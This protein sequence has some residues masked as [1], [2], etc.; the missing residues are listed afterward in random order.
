MSLV[1]AALALAVVLALAG[2]LGELL[3]ANLDQRASGQRSGR[4]HLRMAGERLSVEASGCSAE[5]ASECCG[6][7][8]VAYG[9]DL[10][11]EFLSSI[12][13]GD[14]PGGGF[15]PNAIGWKELGSRLWKCSSCAAYLKRD[16]AFGYKSP[17]TSERRRGGSDNRALMLLLGE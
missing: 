14:M 12:G 9:I 3:E 8:E 15:G 17:K 13:S 11:E 1:T 7:C 16:H 2:V 5:E 6:H 4:G 10:H